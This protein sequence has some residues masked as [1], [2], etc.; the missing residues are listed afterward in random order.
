MRWHIPLN[1]TTFQPSKRTLLKPS[2]SSN[3]AKT[4]SIPIRLNMQRFCLPQHLKPTPY[5]RDYAK[6]SIQWAN[7]D[8]RH[9]ATISNPKFELFLIMRSERGNGCTTPQAVDAALKRH[10]PRYNKR[11]PNSQF[12]RDQI[13]EAVKNAEAKRASCKEAISAAGMTDVYLLAKRPLKGSGGIA[14]T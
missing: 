5:S 6:P 2:P 12:R 7:E 10:L 4:I 1:G 9:H 8:S 3:R 14:R 13:T 11:L